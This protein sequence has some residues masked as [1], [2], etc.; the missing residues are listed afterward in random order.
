LVGPIDRAVLAG[1]FAENLAAT[2]RHA[3]AGGYAGWIDD[4][5]AFVQPWGFALES[6]QCPVELWQGDED[7]MVP[8]AHSHW[9]DRKMPSARLNFVKGQG[10]V[11]LIQNF[12]GAILDQ[13]KQ[14]LY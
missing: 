12:R 13:V 8:S 7:L 5:L 10:H 2:M 1:Q 9:L 14:L 3:L 11:S 4:D 6:I